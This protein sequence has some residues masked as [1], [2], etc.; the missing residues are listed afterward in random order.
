MMSLTHN[1]EALA[2][3]QLS[4]SFA[5]LKD[6]P[7]ERG[8]YQYEIRVMGI[9]VGV[10]FRDWQPGFRV[11]R[12]CIGGGQGAVFWNLHLY[13]GDSNHAPCPGQ[14]W[15]LPAEGWRTLEEAK[16][17]LVVAFDAPLMNDKEWVEWRQYDLE[18]VFNW[19]AV[20]L[21]SLF[22]E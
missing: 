8:C 15:F 13:E 4:V 1:A 20:M 18:A 17:D 6:L 12:G 9:P 14:I 3:V 21:K 19:L 7:K 16:R 2:S 22:P 10:I 11:P 5:V